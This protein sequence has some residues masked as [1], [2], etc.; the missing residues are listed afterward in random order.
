MSINKHLFLV[1]NLFG[2]D[3][4]VDLIVIF[5]YSL[6]NTKKKKIVSCIYAASQTNVDVVTWLLFVT[7]V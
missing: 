7:G 6:T 2:L 3:L 5:N 1:L 4:I